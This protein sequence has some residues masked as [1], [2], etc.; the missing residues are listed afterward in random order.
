MS[1]IEYSHHEPRVVLLGVASIQL[2]KFVVTNCLQNT[3]Q[4][5]TKF[6]RIGS[7]FPP[8]RVFVFTIAIAWAALRLSS[9]NLDAQSPTTS[10]QVSDLSFDRNRG[11]L[12]VRWR[13]GFPPYHVRF[14]SDLNGSWTEHP[15]PVSTNEFTMGNPEGGS[16]FFQV[17]TEFEPLEITAVNFAA[18]AHFVL[19]QWKG[20][21]P[22]FQVQLFDPSTE[23]WETLPELLSQRHF[24]GF[25]PG[26]TRLFRIASV[27]DFIP[28]QPPAELALLGSR[29][30]RILI[31]WQGADDGLTGS[32]LSGYVVYRDSE[33]IRQLAPGCRMFLDEALVPNSIYDYQIAAIDVMGN[34]G[35]PSPP[36]SVLTPD[37]F[38]AATNVYYE[39]RQLTL[40]WDRNEEQTVAGY[41]VY[42][43]TEPG[44]YPWQIDTMQSNAVTISD[45]EPGA[46]YF[47]S[48]TAYTVESI[49]SE[50]APELIFI[51]P[52]PTESAFAAKNHTAP[53]PEPLAAKVRLP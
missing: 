40:T 37:C 6:P 43:G 26:D 47:V 19:L 46:A 42:W 51:P 25:S 50:P 1:S 9:V 11:T 23:E 18:D 8:G 44:V 10:I 3:A 34:E 16:L 13:G 5:F 35:A 21:T 17:R 49:E 48:V 32:G 36:L 14:S 39:N 41:I 29:C 30:D 4:A 20:G 28:P 53:P 22:P 31:G 7:G 27:P 33:R 15:R 2:V 12:T 52:S 45:L 24:E 38:V